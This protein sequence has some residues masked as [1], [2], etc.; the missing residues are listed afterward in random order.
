MCL[1]AQLGEEDA[2][3]LSRLCLDAEGATPLETLQL[4]EGV[5]IT[6]SPL[7]GVVIMRGEE[8]LAARAALLSLL[9]RERWGSEGIACDDTQA[10]LLLA[11]GSA[12][13]EL[14]EACTA[15]GVVVAMQHDP[16]M[17]FV[18]G[19]THVL[20]AAKQ[21]AAAWL[22]AHQAAQRSLTIPPEVVPQ[23][24]S[25]I[26]SLLPSLPA[27]VTVE[28]GEDDVLRICGPECSVDATLAQVS[29]FVRRHARREE[30]LE[31]SAEGVAL[32]CLLRNRNILEGVELVREGE[33]SVLLKGTEEGVG[34][35]IS[36]LEAVLSEAERCGV[37]LPLNLAQLEKLCRTMGRERET[38]LRKLQETHECALIADRQLMQ[39]RLH[40]RAEAVVRMQAAIEV[41]L[42]IDEHVR[43][44]SSQASQ[45]GV[46]CEVALWG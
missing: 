30:R 36:R 1:L 42:D 23:L 6:F 16:P 11:A 45:G 9:A 46:W 14:Q 25:G 20:A 19:A 40:G 12:L 41:E 15:E 32:A 3:L 18:S 43:S 44:I 10:E 22:S 31:L 5:A 13:E 27:G 38:L 2:E 28:M 33:C 26:S 4:S 39:L 17:V 37:V 29:T 24:R 35:A 21:Q 34:K 7:S 8:T